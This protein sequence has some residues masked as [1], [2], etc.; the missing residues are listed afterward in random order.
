[1]KKFVYVDGANVAF[2]VHGSGP[3]VMLLHGT[4]G[5]SETNWSQVAGLLSEHYTVIRPDYSG[6]GATVD[7][8]RV[9][10]MATLAAQ[11]V[12]A[13][14]HTGIRPLHLVGFSLGG[15]L[16]TYVAAEFPSLVRSL[17][18]L[19][20]PADS[21]DT[22]QTL[23]FELWRDLIRTDRRAMARL[24]V[25][26]G[27]SPDFLAAMD[28]SQVRTII[29]QVIATNNWEGM[30]RQVDLD[31]VLDV[32]D[33]ARRVTQPALIVGCTHDQM[34][35]LA[36]A[37]PLATLIPGARYLEIATGHLSTVERPDEVARLIHEF[38][39]EIKA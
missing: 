6:S 3:G 28:A 37:R 33:Q 25:L 24:L 11:V 19:S 39:A 1:M 20:G 27:L 10:N 5:N 36:A 4:G 2:H 35:P 22:R 31:L 17:V 15:S 9:L 18:V 30:A 13:A 21:A 23:Q 14:E 7:N 29:E 12:A 16:A 8:G 26:T 32:R 34:V 38:V